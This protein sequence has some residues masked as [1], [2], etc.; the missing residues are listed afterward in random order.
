MD[1]GELPEGMDMPESEITTPHPS[2]SVILSRECVDGHEILLGHRVSEL[3]AFPDVWAFPGGGISR[4]DKAAAQSHPEWLSDRGADRVSTFALLR[5]IVEELGVAPDGSGGFYEVSAEVRKLV[6]SD[7]SGWLESME[8][9]ELTTDGFHCEMITERITPPQAPAR[10]HNLFFH[11]PTGNPGVT[12]TFPPG[13]SEFDEFRWWRP[14]DLIASWESNEIRLPPPL[15]TL[16]RDLVEAIEN[17]GDLQSACDALA[18]DPPSGRHRF[19]YG[20]GVEC[21][22][23]PTDTLPPATHTNCFILGERGGERVIVDPASR[24][25]E[26]LEELAL[27]VQEIH[28]DGSSITATIFTHRHPDH[29][30][31]LA[32]ISE[33]YQ[34]PIWASQETLASIAPCETDRVLSEGNS[35]VLEGPSG[36][37]RWEVIESPGH[38][39]GQICLVGESGVVSG[40]NCT[41]V[42]TILVPSG[43][44]DMGAY[45]SGLER[46][47]DLKPKVLFPGHG[48]LVANPERVLTEY[49]EHRKA[50]HQK[51]LEAVRAGNSDILSIAS[52]AYSDSPGAHPLL[53]QDQALSHLKELQKTGDVEN[54]GSGYTAA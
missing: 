42:G 49:I 12:P 16:A 27:K 7:K 32:R 13:R 1:M 24:D 38:C 39:P 34:A 40:D 17:E 30:G 15:V 4:V 3:P 18:A 33:I 48:P 11:V 35:F 47:R 21:V 36:G 10:F 46:I 8:S 5:E 50:R 44:G 9:G 14:A 28:D 54:D 23:I 43:E 25:E 20:P 19:E 6:C 41:L 45:I 52:A 29:V 37:A 53:A 26:G 2:A 22:L 51:V 31:D